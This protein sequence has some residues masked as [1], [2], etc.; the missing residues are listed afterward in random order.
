MLKSGQEILKA[1]FGYDSFRPMQEKVVRAVLNNEDCLVLMPTGGGKSLCYQVPALAKEGT[2]LVVSPLIALMKDQ[3]EAL[4]QNGVSAAFYNSS[5]SASEQN[6][7]INDLMNGK[8]KLLYV[9]PERL[10]SEQF[11]QVLSQ[12]KISLIAI[13]EAHCISSW[14]HDFRPDYKN[15]GYLRNKYPNIPI[16][17]LTAT[18][19]TL[20]QEDIL[21][22]L[23]L[24]TAQVFKDTFSRPNIYIEMQGAQKRKQ[25]ILNFLNGRHEESG[26]IYCLS[27]KSTED[28]SAF[29]SGNGISAAHYHAGMSNNERDRVQSDFLDDSIK[30][31]C[32]TIAFGMG[33]DKSN[34]R[35]VIHYNMPKNIEG[36]YQ[37]IGR[38]GRDGLPAT[39]LLF[40][41]FQDYRILK[42][43]NDESPRRYL[44]DARLDRMFNMTKQYHCRR[45]ML[46]NYFGEWTNKP[47]GNCDN[48]K[49]Q[50]GSYDG[51]LHAQKAL[52][53]VARLPQKLS[54]S[55]LARGL[56]G[57]HH[58][59][60]AECGFTDIK[61]F[62][63]GRNTD[64]KSWMFIIEQLLSLGLLQV[65]YENNCTL[66]LTATSK[67]VLFEGLKVNLYK[68]GVR[69]KATK[70][71]LT[72]KTA[73][74]SRP[75]NTE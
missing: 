8:L 65:D 66:Q 6:S 17:A 34:V 33:I 10:N 60:V 20:T 51:T 61:T 29:L 73:P 23:N 27:K 35:W 12:T 38:S 7:V 72:Q 55:I 39:A 62:G 44:L 11:H 71:E 45:V 56:M 28:I 16:V 58:E 59:D 70:S 22:Q 21:R 13:D 26:I 67:K 43:I 52:S 74:K 15:M 41:G 9:S 53:A 24:D 5:I 50:L 57:W 54:N 14:G 18:A 46:L 36:Y 31:V 19:D 75:Q 63:V 40:A 42:D 37:E 48:C 64:F 3:V 4:K 49:R 32:A 1:V 30:V 2:A 25:K 69:M 68:E 47:C